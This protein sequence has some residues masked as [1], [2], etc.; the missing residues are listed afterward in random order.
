M[1]YSSSSTLNMIILSYIF[2]SVF[3]FGIC[4]G[5][6]PSNI[7]KCYLSRKQTDVISLFCHNSY[8]VNK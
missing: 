3:S 4:I 2:I 8:D 6:Y 7:F 1:P 5:A